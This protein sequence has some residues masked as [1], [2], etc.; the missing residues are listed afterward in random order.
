MGVSGCSSWRWVE[1]RPLQGDG[2]QVRASAG[3]GDLAATSDPEPSGGSFCTGAWPY[4]VQG[5]RA[6]AMLVPEQGV[7]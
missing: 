7:K 4:P 6:Q 2:A 1:Q 5:I 3:K